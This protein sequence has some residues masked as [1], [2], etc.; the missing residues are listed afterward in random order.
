LIPTY[1]PVFRYLPYL[2]ELHTDLKRQLLNYGIWQAELKDNAIIGYH[3][4]HLKTIEEDLEIL[5]VKAQS[6]VEAADKAISMARVQSDKLQVQID[7]L[8]ENT[9]Q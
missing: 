8:L 6:T 1:Y 4:S 5:L 2:N 3:G 9:R 7:N